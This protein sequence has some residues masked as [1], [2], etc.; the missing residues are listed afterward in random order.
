MDQ[1]LLGW[2]RE[3]LFLQF[4]SLA[5]WFL[6]QPLPIV[7]CSIVPPS[8]WDQTNTIH[9]CGCPSSFKD[10]FY[11]AKTFWE[12]LKRSLLRI[13]IW[14]YKS[15]PSGLK[16]K[17]ILSWHH[18][19][20]KSSWMWILAKLLFFYQIFKVILDQVLGHSLIT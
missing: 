5:S 7:L 11:Q 3:L 12:H 4:F 10:C 9:V 17:F 20:A 2:I 1:L 14:N 13:E 16:S 8:Y 19:Y 15:S 6:R 18:C